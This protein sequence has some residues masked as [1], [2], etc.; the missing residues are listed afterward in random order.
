MR[1]E[2]KRLSQK[3]YKRVVQI[4]LI[5]KNNTKDNMSTYI[6]IENINIQSITMIH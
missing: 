5:K 4:S 1:R 6:V 2:N 3:L